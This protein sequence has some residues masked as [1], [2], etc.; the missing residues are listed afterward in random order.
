MGTFSQE[1]IDLQRSPIFY[2]TM[3]KNLA[4]AYSKKTNEAVIAKVVA[5]GTQGTVQAATVAGL[6]AFHSL[7]SIAAYLATGDPATSFIM[8]GSIASL[9]IGAT[10]STGRPIF[11]S[12]GNTAN[13]GGSVTARAGVTRGDFLGLDAFLDRG[14]VATS[15]DDSCFIVVPS[16]LLLLEKAP[17]KLMVAQLGAGQYEVSLHGY[18]AQVTQVAAGMRRFNV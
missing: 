3:L 2:D 11:N 10:D 6:I 17:Q 12:I 13:A 8:G 16:S 15:I 18:L 4:A 5:D 9:L 7:E 14:M 1:M